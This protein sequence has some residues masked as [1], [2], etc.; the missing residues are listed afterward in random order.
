MERI[1]A[2]ILEKYGMDAFQIGL[3][4]F[5]SWKFITNHWKHFTDKIDRIDKNV[6]GNARAINKLS[7]RV[8]K[9][10]GKLDK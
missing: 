2:T 6:K 8:S 4:V 9:V 3:I 1:L 5:I 10:E 7:E